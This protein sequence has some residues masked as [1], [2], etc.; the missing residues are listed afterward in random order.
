MRRNN[1]MAWGYGLGSMMRVGENLF[2][3]YFIYYLSTVA[4]VDPATAGAI[5]G[6][7]LLVGAFCSPVLGHLS[8][9]CRSRYGQRRPFMIVTALPAMGLLVLLFTKVDLG[10]STGTYYFVVAL[11][12]SV[13]Y[14]A[15]LVPYDALG[16][17]LTTDYGPSAPLYAAFVPPFCIS[18]CW[19]AA[20]WWSKCKPCSNRS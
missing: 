2:A 10:E 18:L 17:N 3:F 19:L 6:T 11:L 14:Y 12:F 5:S 15:F 8:D 20:R 16:A 13:M 7:A 9:R 1:G 4:G